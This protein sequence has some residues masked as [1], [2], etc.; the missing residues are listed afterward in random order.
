MLRNLFYLLPIPW[1]I[2]LI[3]LFLWPLFSWRIDYLLVHFWL[4]KFDEFI[5]F[6]EKFFVEEWFPVF[7]RLAHDPIPPGV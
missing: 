7:A 6:F 4:I 2:K 3:R 5:S 1:L